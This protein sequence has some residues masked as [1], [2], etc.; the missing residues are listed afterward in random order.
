MARRLTLGEFQLQMID[1]V[2]QYFAWTQLMA[3]RHE[4]AAQM[5]VDQPEDVI[6]GEIGDE[7]PG[8][9][10][11][12]APAERQAAPP[13]IVAQRGKARSVKSPSALGISPS[14]PVVS[15]VAE[16]NRRKPFCAPSAEVSA[17]ISKAGGRRQRHNDPSK[18]R[19]GLKKFAAR[20]PEDVRQI[21][22]I[23]WVKRVA[24]A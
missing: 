18:A 14:L 17:P 8:E 19:D 24:R 21:A 2:R 6:G 13:G 20:S 9:K 7:E 4:I 1:N 23:Q 15:N 5:A 22:L 3:R 11:M 12:P 16:P 10:E